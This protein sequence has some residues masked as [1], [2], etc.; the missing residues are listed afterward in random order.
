M[1]VTFRNIVRLRV[2][3]VLLVVAAF[4]YLVLEAVAAAA[5]TTPPYNYA[6]NFISDLGNPILGDVY[7]ERAIRSPLNAVMDTAFIVQGALFI[8]S[9]L[10]LSSFLARAGRRWFPV[11]L[12]V[13]AFVHG[14]GVILVGL[15]QES[16]TALT[17]GVIVVHSL[18]AAG[19]ILAGNALAMVVGITARQW[20]AATWYRVLS[21]VLG[22][23][24][25]GAFVLL[26]SY[27]PLYDTAGGIP[28][29]I[30]VYAIVA[31]EAVTG[32]SLLIRSRRGRPQASEG[33]LA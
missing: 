2:G 20:D 24:G 18:G 26:L 3:G 17:N 9:A 30:A 25:I 7:E 5:W 23:I 16:S 11:V 27:R 31:W 29:R 12:L 19:T 4:Q 33:V 22:V 13:L 21:I 1:N 8:V 28:E 32:V 10:L 14:I 15:F 6:V